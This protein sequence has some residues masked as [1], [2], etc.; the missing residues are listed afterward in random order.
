LEKFPATADDFLWAPGNPIVLA[1][2]HKAVSADADAIIR[3]AVVAEPGRL[4]AA[5]CENTLKQLTRFASGDGLETWQSQVGSWIDGDFPPRERTA[6]HAARQQLGTLSVP[7]ALLHRAAALGGIAAALI[8]LPAA[9]RRHP[10]AARFLLLSLLTLPISAAITGGLSAPHDRYQ[11]RIIWLPAAM[12]FLTLP[13]L[14]RERR[15]GGG[16]W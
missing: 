3:A 1:G 8:M 11:S 14:W 9:W 12:A 10:A 2:G 4:F 7:L 16:S 5:A 13:A 6:F 15:R